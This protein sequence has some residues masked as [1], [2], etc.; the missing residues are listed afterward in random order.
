MRLINTYIGFDRDGTLE[1]PNVEMPDNLVTQLQSLVQL[2]ARLFI[3]S[4][5]DYATL[6]EICNNINLNPWMVCAEN[7]G[8]IVIPSE[9]I[10]YIYADQNSH[11]EIFKH[12][13]DLLGLPEYFQEPKLSIWSK[14]FGKNVLLAQEKINHFINSKN[15]DLQV[16]AYPDG[17]GGLDVV[18]VG[19]DKS[20]LMEYIPQNAVIH[21]FGDGGNDLGLMQ[22]TNVI[23]HTVSNAAAE[24]KI[25]VKNKNGYI[26]SFPAGVGVSE[27]LTDLFRV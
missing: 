24:V 21:Y 14:K 12:N 13:V 3:A 19:I 9:N 7:G 5:K 26:A 27:L 10:N 23:P 17:D 25:C 16:Y 6:I 8:H 4:G 22:H 15:L 20:K 1:M 18:P 11:L 2:G